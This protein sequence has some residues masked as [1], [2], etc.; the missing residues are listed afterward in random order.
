[1]SNANDFAIEDGVLR[2][3]TGT[4]SDVV[5]PDGVTSIGSWAF[6]GCKNLRSIVIPDSVTELGYG[7]FSGCESLT[8]ITIPDGVTSIGDGAFECCKNLQSITIPDSLKGIGGRMFYD[9][10]DL[11]SI[12]IPLL[13]V[14]IGW[15]AFSGCTSLQSITIPDGVTSIS[16]KAFSD[17]TNLT[18]ITIPNSVTSIGNW[19]F[20]GCESLTSITIPSGATSIG[21]RA[22]SGCTS[23]TS[24]TI[25]SGATSIG[26]GAFYGC[27]SL[28][29]IP[30]LNGVTRIGKEAF[31]RCENLASVTIPDGVTSIGDEAFYRCESLTSISIPGSVTSIGNNAFWSCGKLT[32]INVATGNPKYCSEDGVLFSQSKTA[33]IQYPEGNTR[34]LYTIPDGVTSIGKQAF[35]GCESLTSITIPDGVTSIGFEAFQGCTSLQSITIPD[36][37]TSIDSC[38][39]EKCKSLQSVA[40]SEHLTSISFGAF[41]SC[42]NLTSITIPNGVTSIDRDAFRYCANLQSITIPGSVTSIEDLAF[43]DCPRLTNIHIEDSALTIPIKAFGEITEGLAHSCGELYPHLTDAAIK[44]CLSYTTVWKELESAAK[45]KMFCERH[46]KALLDC[47]AICMTAEDAE[48]ISRAVLLRLTTSPDKQDITAAVNLM[49]MFPRQLPAG[50]LKKLYSAIQAIP[51][52]ASSLKTIKKNTILTDILNSASEDTA[53]SASSE[54]SAAEQTMNALAEKVVLEYLA[55]ENLTERGAE[56]KLK[57]FYGI[58]SADLPAVTY[59]DGTAVAPF[60]LA[61]LLT[62]H[63]TQVTRYGRACVEA[64][65]L[66]PGV[67]PEAAEVL[68]YLDRKSWQDV[69]KALANRGFGVAK[70]LYLAYPICRYADAKLMSEIYRQAPNW[71]SATYG[72]NETL[73]HVRTACLYSEQRAALLLVEK[74]GG[75]S[76]YAKIHGT[77]V[78]KLR[79]TVLID[80]GFDDNG[81]KQYELGGTTVTVSLQKD[82]SL[83]LTDNGKVIKTLPKKGSDAALFD[84]ASD[85]LTDLRQNMKKTVTDQRNKLLAD[86][87]SGHALSC[88]RWKTRYLSNVLLRRIAELL[89]WEQDGA[90]FTLSGKDAILADGTAYAVTGKPIKLA[91]PME[92]KSAEI[93]VWQQYFNANGLKQPFAQIWEPVYDLSIVDQNRYNGIHIPAYHFKGREKDGIVLNFDYNQSELH[94]D[95]GDCD[96]TVDGGTAV[97]WHSLDLKG[98]LILGKFEVKKPSRQANHVVSLLDKWTVYGRIIKDD[99]AV[100]EQLNAANIAQIMEYI[101]VAGENN[102]VNVTAALLDYKNEHF[103]D[104]DPM[105][106]FVL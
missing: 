43:C 37:V 79:D 90:T 82:L 18:S 73:R 63:E 64:D 28:T 51:G 93:K 78:E 16:E 60:V 36:S 99:V 89:V 52:T 67:R 97:D 30:I 59:T 17:C 25:P 11:Q 42:T 65:Y 86:F 81:Q 15:S 94:I 104:F 100:M 9:C 32:M 96:L 80:F 44:A 21:D 39:F 40:L 57:S 101:R 69:L 98:E 24:I 5:I 19:A 62:L 58:N 14:S 87:L 4:N 54:T 33:L 22:F 55:K 75:I 41:R 13:C 106:E 71:Y 20:S 85:D 35:Y 102:A 61:W 84:A 70:K 92:M 27:K 105:D 3:Y 76:Y 50:L 2:K 68:A 47:Y 83:V 26:E 34:A 7:A 77:S 46:S 48:M 31:Y 8:T 95:T 56:A 66:K 103:A 88:S 91:H 74:Y 45:D 6:R 29:G 49:T 72:E 12:T 23:L 1:M 38:V 10:R 53:E